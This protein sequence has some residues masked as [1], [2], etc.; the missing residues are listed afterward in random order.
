MGRSPNILGAIELPNT[1]FPQRSMDRLVLS[2]HEI[3]DDTFI[4]TEYLPDT[5]PMGSLKC[6]N[7]YLCTPNGGNGNTLKAGPTVVRNRG[8]FNARPSGLW[9]EDSFRR[10]LVYHKIPENQGVHLARGERVVSVRGRGDYG[11]T[12]QIEGG[13]Q[14][15]RQASR[16]AET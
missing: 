8:G 15:Y 6:A 14:H 16:F 4:A 1:G 2:L 13:V 9:D 3:T 10:E 12:F 7:I 11:L 5:R